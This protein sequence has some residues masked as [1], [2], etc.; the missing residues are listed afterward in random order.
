M[1]NTEVREAIKATGYRYSLKPIH[2]GKTLAKLLA[3]KKV[4]RD[5]K[6]SGAKYTLATKA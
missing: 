6:N 4:V 5:G 3:D 2:V 1:N